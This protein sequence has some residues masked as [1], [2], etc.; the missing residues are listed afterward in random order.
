MPD[1]VTRT[2]MNNIVRIVVTSCRQTVVRHASILMYVESM[3]PSCQSSYASRED[4]LVLVAGHHNLPTH[5]PSHITL[6]CAPCGCHFY[7]G[8]HNE[9]Y[10][11]PAVPPPH[12]GENTQKLL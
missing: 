6:G 10:H 4:D 9:Y 12:L 11:A 1:C 7:G 8:K 5:R 3:L 2:T